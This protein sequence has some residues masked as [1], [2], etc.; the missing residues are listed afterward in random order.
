MNLSLKDKVIIVTGGSKG[1]GRA[2]SHVLADE[3]AIPFIVSRDEKSILKTVEEIEK[4][5]ANVCDANDCVCN[6]NDGVVDLAI[7]GENLLIEK[8]FF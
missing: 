7:I 1:I 4:K 5:V 3:G 2:I 8:D 6:I